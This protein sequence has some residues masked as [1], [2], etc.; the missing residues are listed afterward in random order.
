MTKSELKTGMIVE[1]REG[2][3]YQVLLGTKH[4]DVLVCDEGW[5]KL[6]SSG[7][8]LL[9]EKYAHY[10]SLDIM[11]VRQPTGGACY[12]HKDW[13]IADVIWTRPPKVDPYAALKAAYAE[14]K[15]IEVLGAFS[16]IWIVAGS[17]K[18]DAPVASY[19]IK[20]TEAISIKGKLYS[21]DT[22]AEALRSYCP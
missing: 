9:H 12:T 1:T 21:E 17:P 5:M 8:S 10:E 11:E 7:E 19:R 2:G 4:G 6:S 16:H 13:D 22:I 3:V 20:P 18:W 14:G 15:A